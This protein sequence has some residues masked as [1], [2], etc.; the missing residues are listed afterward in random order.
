MSVASSNSVH[1]AVHDLGGTGPGP[2]DLARDRVPRSVLPADRARARRTATTRSRS[3]TAATATRRSP[4]ACRSIGSATATTPL[5][6]ARSF[7]APVRAFGHS[8]GGA[9]LLMAAHR[10]PAV[11]ERLVVFEPIVFPPPDEAPPT[12]RR[13][14]RSSPERG[15][16]AATFALLRRGARRTTRASPRSAASRPEALDAYVRH[17]F[18]AGEDGQVHLKCAPEVEAG[19]FELGGKHRTWDV[20]PEIEVPVLVLAGSRRRDPAEPRRRA[21]RGA[22]AERPVPCSSTTSTTSP[23]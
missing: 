17:G 8:M 9:C 21:A 7:D 11:F 2:P 5:A 1:L 14:T 19:T 4:T 23:R 12:M 6:M 15:A 20:L 22:A 3:T 10:D 16:G 13:P 18:A